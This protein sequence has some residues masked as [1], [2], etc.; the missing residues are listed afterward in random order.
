MTARFL[1]LTAT[2]LLAATAGRAAAQLKAFPGAQGAGQY[3][4]GGRGGDVYRVTKLSDYTSS[5][6]P[7][8]ERQ[9]TLRH[10]ISSATGPRTIVFDVGGTIQL[11]DN[12]SVNKSNITIAGQTAPGPGITLRD[13]T[14]QVSSSGSNTVSD[15][16]VRHLRSRKGDLK[17]S[18]DAAGVLGS[19]TT[20]NIILD[21]ISASWGE[22]EVL[23]VTNNATNVTVQYSNIS[24]GLNA[25]GH[26]FGSLIRPQVNSSVTFHHNL[27]ANSQSRQPRLGTYNDQLLQFEFRNNVVYNWGDRA[28]YAGGSSEP[29]LEHVDLNFIGNYL[30]A[31]PSTP[32]D[33]RHRRAF[34][35]DRNVDLEIFQQGNLIDSDRD[36]QRDG[37]DTGW[38]MIY[39]IPGTTGTM[40]QRAAAFAFPFAM[41]ETDSAADAYAK[42][43]A[44]A[45]AMPWNRDATDVRIFA[46]VSNGTGALVNS[47]NAAEWQALVNALAVSRP[48]GWDSDGDGMPNS[49]ESANGM[50][51]NA[52]DN[53]LV[54]P[55]GY[56]A[57]EHYLNSIGTVPEPAGAALLALPALAMRRR[58]RA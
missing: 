51:P 14:F 42:V 56:T 38:A 8:A 26:G 7:L 24:E 9:G 27:F 55:D 45:G 33:G 1:A 21:H 35:K 2:A 57:L 53:N 10:A 15:V 41:S 4:T 20:R 31:G 6:I 48:A 18:Q 11:L 43:I 37:T 12:L 25:G 36:A 39:S 28:G 19:G 58:R 34:S 46:D 54:R 49:W 22:D 50:N 29:E 32:T 30:I 23:S 5:S 47:P 13:Y 44:G 16:I 3:A 17:D 40:T 52:A